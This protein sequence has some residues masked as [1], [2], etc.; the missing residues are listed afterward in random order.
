MLKCLFF[1]YKILYYFFNTFKNDPLFKN[2]VGSYP[3]Y[4]TSYETY[5]LVSKYMDP[6]FNGARLL[7]TIMA[8]L[9]FNVSSS[10]LLPFNPVTYSEQLNYEY[11]KFEKNY[12]DKLLQLNV[13]L[14]DLENVVKDFEKISRDFS[15]RLHSIDKTK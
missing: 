1:K 12:K 8:D 6:N 9:T 2:I 13:S 3:L 10:L 11:K 14:I 15:N 5:E 4:H 7:A